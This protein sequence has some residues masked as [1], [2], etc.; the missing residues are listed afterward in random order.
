[1]FF[2][3]IFVELEMDFPSIYIWNLIIY[4]K[5]KNGL[6]SVRYQAITRTQADL[7]VMGH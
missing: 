1:M 2:W 4:L 6:T 5:K 3:N 7:S